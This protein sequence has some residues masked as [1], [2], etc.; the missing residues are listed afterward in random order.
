MYLAHE[1]DNESCLY[2]VVSGSFNVSQKLPD[3]LGDHTT[4]L[5][6]ATVGELVGTLAVL[7][8]EPSLFNIR[9]KQQ[10]KVLM[11]TR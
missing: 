3:R 9:A 11:I 10:S 5:F 7:T 8:G 1:F 2:Y 6:N 4:H